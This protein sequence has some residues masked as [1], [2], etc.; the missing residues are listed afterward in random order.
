MDRPLTAALKSSGVSGNAPRGIALPGHLS[1]EAINAVLRQV[2]QKSQL[3]AVEMTKKKNTRSL[4]RRAKSARRRAASVDQGLPT[5]ADISDLPRPRHVLAPSVPARGIQFSL[6]GNGATALVALRQVALIQQWHVKLGHATHEHLCKTLK[7]E[8]PKVWA[9]VR[10]YWEYYKR[11]VFCALCYMYR[12]SKAPRKSITSVSVT[13]PWQRFGMDLFR[14][15]RKQAQYGYTTALIIV[16]FF[17]SYGWIFPLKAKSDVVLALQHW[18]RAVLN[19]R[20][21]PAPV[22]G[23]ASG[24]QRQGSDA[25][26]QPTMWPMTNATFRA[27]RDSVFTSAQCSQMLAQHNVTLSTSPA[28]QQW[29]NGKAESFMRELGYAVSTIKAERSIPEEHTVSALRSAVQCLNLRVTVSRSTGEGLPMPVTAFEAQLG[30][31]PRMD[32]IYVPMCA[33][34]LLLRAELRGSASAGNPKSKGVMVCCR[35]IDMLTEPDCPGGWQLWDPSSRHHSISAEVKFNECLSGLNYDRP[36]LEV[37]RLSKS[38][39]VAAGNLLQTSAPRESASHQPIAT[40]AHQDGPDAELQTPPTADPAQQP[41]AASASPSD[42]WDSAVDWIQYPIKMSLSTLA[43]KWLTKPATLKRWLEKFSHPMFQDIPLPARGVTPPYWKPKT[44]L[45]S[46]GTPENRHPEFAALE[47][48][49]SG[50]SAHQASAS[51]ATSATPK[52]N[53]RAAALQALAAAAPAVSVRQRLRPKQAAHIAMKAGLVPSLCDQ[54]SIYVEREQDQTTEKVCRVAF[55]V[56]ALQVLAGKNKLVTPTSLD[57][58]LGGAEAEQWVEAISKEIESLNSFGTVQ[59]IKKSDIPRGA[60]IMKLKQVYKFKFKTDGKFDKA[61]F[62]ITCAGYSQRPGVD[63]KVSYAP[64]ASMNSL[65]LL[66][67]HTAKHDLELSMLDYSSAF[68]QGAPDSCDLYVKLE[69]SVLETIDEGQEQLYG[70][71]VG[72]LYGQVQGP[73]GW[74]STLSYFLRHGTNSIEVT[75]TDPSPSPAPPKSYKFTPSA[76]DR[77]IWFHKFKRDDGSAGIIIML[78][79]VDDSL[80]AFK[81]RDQELLKNIKLSLLSRFKGTSEDG[82]EGLLGINVTRNR[83]RRTLKIDQADYIATLAEKFD[84]T[85][86]APTPMHYAGLYHYP[87][88]GKEVTNV[89]MR[90]YLSIVQACAWCQHTVPEIAYAVGRLARFGQEPKTHHFQAALRLLGYL[91]GVRHR[92][93]TYSADSRPLASDPALRSDDL[94]VFTD[95]SL[96][97][98]GDKTLPNLNLEP[99]PTWDR[100]VSGLAIMYANAI[101]QGSADVQATVKF[102]TAGAEH[103]ALSRASNVGMEHRNM[104]IEFEGREQPPLLVMGSHNLQNALSPFTDRMPNLDGPASWRSHLPKGGIA[105]IGDNM[106]SLQELGGVGHGSRLKHL[107]LKAIYNAALAQQGHM[108]PFHLP[109]K[110]LVADIFTKCTL[111]GGEDDFKVQRGIITGTNKG[112]T[113]HDLRPIMTVA[114]CRLSKKRKA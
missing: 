52:C 75:F 3:P 36:T 96:P 76:T 89:D 49:A 107:R 12:Q 57:E 109:T 78:V 112:W 41:D 7:T 114:D 97:E 30:I 39:L 38:P 79:F 63:Y 98:P 74:G 53:S 22:L 31:K 34:T 93:I 15:M 26:T 91:L 59:L 35:A 4:A 88:N 62:R 61:K 47:S 23:A 86:T 10:Y 84:V 13:A 50:T 25:Q 43:R 111:S 40:S 64:T 28:E 55:N 11:H 103:D 110:Q 14:S 21:H 77:S 95:A 85:E 106:S 5:Q 71:V 8:L 54:A 99:K 81:S 82:C 1:Q 104:L 56:H 2:R 24:A 60:L 66:L 100:P 102:S 45:P 83:D 51:Y 37:V 58:A 20:R 70:R 73:A 72:P 9:T 108:I 29:Q 87:I 65:R 113:L 42:Q 32:M 27:D 90:D 80:F 92:G 68:A 18:I 105:V 48:S 17:T 19:S 67:A 94:L 16:D 6:I 46:P 33:A 69:G 44:D 101:V